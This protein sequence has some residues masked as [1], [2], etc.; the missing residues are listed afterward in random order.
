MTNEKEL[1]KEPDRDAHV[2]GVFDA[3]MGESAIDKLFST[4]AYP[5]VEF[6]DTRPQPLQA[7]DKIYE[8]FMKGF[9]LTHLKTTMFMLKVNM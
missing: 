9:K 4:T 7:H 3:D 1:F 6:A 2:Y 8:F 5:L